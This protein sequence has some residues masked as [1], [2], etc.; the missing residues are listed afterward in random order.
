MPKVS[1]SILINAPISQ[2]FS[3]LRNPVN[4]LEIWPSMVDIRDVETDE[5]GRTRFRWTYRMAAFTFEGE[6][7]E[8]EVIPEKRVIAK[9]SGGIPSTFDWQYQEEGGAT[10]LTVDVEYEIPS[11]LGRL[12]TP[13]VTKINENSAETLLANLK[14]RM[15]SEQVSAAA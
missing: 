2:V 11:A 13:F 8:V 7:Q 14:A 9:S 15:E 5:S 10:R 3:Y 4:Q 6:T 12:A 1:R